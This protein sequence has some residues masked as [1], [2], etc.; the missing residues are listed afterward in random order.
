MTPQEFIAKW[1]RVNLTERSACQQHF[2]DLCDLL[3]QPK[4]AA[5]DPDGAWYTF[6][7]GVRKTTGGKGWADVWMRDHFGWEYKGK[8]KDLDAAYRQLNLYREDLQNPA[9]LVVCDLDRFEIHTNFTGTPKDVYRF[10]LEGL[11]EADNLEVLRKLFTKPELLRPGVTTESITRQAAERFGLLADGM[12]VRGV[13]AA[14]AAHFLM[15]LMFCMFGEDIGLL[16]EKVFGRVL[17]GS[18]KQPQELCGRLHALFQAMS[19]GGYFGAVKILYFDG[20]LFADA[21]AV[22]LRPEE[23]EE[24]IR[25]ND[26]DWGNV[27]PSI[28]GTLFERTLDPAK[29][30]QIG[31]HYTSRADILTLLEPVV[32]APLRREW[33]EVKAKCDKLWEQVKSE[34]PK[35]SPKARKPSR[36]ARDLERNL[37]DF[38]ERLAHVKIL[39]PACGSGN[40]LYVAINLLL[41]LEKQVIAY[42]AGR[43]VSMIPH[44]RPTQLAGI[45][46]NPYAQQLAQVVIWI[47]YLQWMHH[48]GFRAPTDPVLEPIETI[49]LKDAILDLTD[50]ENPK[51]PDWPEADYIVGNPPFLGDK[52]M[53]RGLGNDYVDML[54]PIYETSVPGQADLCCYWF[55]KARKQVVKSKCS[56]AGLLGTQGIRGGENRRVLDRI[57]RDGDI[58]WAESDRNWI[59][60]GATVHVSMVG[61]DDGTETNRV[62]DATAVARI[63]ADLSASVDLTNAKRIR[64]N[65]GVA[66]IGTQKGGS[67]DIVF[68]K[69]IQLLRESGNPNSRPN[70]DVV[71]PWV[72]GSDITKRGRD[73][74]IIDFGA[75]MSLEQAAMYH[76]PFEHVKELV[77]P[78]RKDVRRE[79]HRRYWWIHAES[80]PGMRT[81][82]LGKNRYI[83]TPRVSKHRL[84]DWLPSEFVADSAVVAIASDDEFLFGLLQSSMHELWSRRT[85]T[86]LR[87]AESGFRYSQSMTFETFPFP[88]PTDAQKTV[89]SSAAKEL[90]GLRT[91]WL[92]PAEWT[93]EEVLEFP[94]SADGPWARY[95]DPATIEGTTP[96]RTTGFQ[97]RR[98]PT[99]LLLDGL[100][101]P[102]YSGESTGLEARRT[103]PSYG[104]IGTVRYPRIVPRDAECAKKLKKRTLTN[105]YN[106]RPTW[107]DLAHKKLDEAVFAAY[108]WDPG[109]SAEELLEKLLALNLE[110]GKT[111]K[112]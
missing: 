98:P 54:R 109:M 27:E 75:S 86:Q 105:L 23:I 103:G 32:M 40:F 102:S 91:A 73:M 13:E 19:A 82:L 35:R 88:E 71:R 100:G 6:E 29:R 81:A 78:C 111:E 5:A 90:D 11:A 3:G 96:E 99:P 10:R 97:A 57:K 66:F 14:V 72:N 48:N 42:G 53:R 4:P 16:P 85:G 84:F 89:I 74:W 61:F 50:P 94:G 33:Q 28:F 80:R 44:V 79:N 58:F 62:L 26:Y 107:L 25:I 108:N 112:S 110:R 1:Q 30:S 51:E 12:R 31:A 92:N 15:K 8:H 65:N 101:S 2:L 67:F 69:A 47:G 22:E 45:E 93:R 87:E 95:I 36:K 24:L 63:N 21:D 49:Q 77:Y 17:Q 43:G 37:L 64:R 7:R 106:E 104:G 20:G 9:L 41:D 18:K 34:A 59:L 68:E 46:I 70:S 52:L 60:D 55:E 38:V 56:R 83:A 39:D 76:S